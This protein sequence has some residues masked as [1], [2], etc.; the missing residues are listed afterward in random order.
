MRRALPLRVGRGLRLVPRARQGAACR[1]RRRG[2]RRPA[3]VLGHVLDGLLRLLHPVMPFVT[4]ELWTALTGGESRR[5]SRRG[6]RGE[7]RPTRD[8]PAAEAEIVALQAAGHRG[9]PVPLR[10]GAQ[11]RPAGGRAARPASRHAARRARGRRSGR[12]C[13]S[14]EPADGF[15]ATASLPVGGRHGRARHRRHHRRRRRAQAAGEGPRGG[16]K[17]ADQADGASSATRQFLAKAP[18][19]GGRR[20]SAPRRPGR[21]DIARLT[22]QLAMPL[23]RA[24]CHACQGEFDRD[25]PESFDFGLPCLGGCRPR[26]DL[27]VTTRNG[28]IGSPSGL[29][30]FL[31]QGE[32]LRPP[33][34]R[35]PKTWSCRRIGQRRDCRSKLEGLPW[36]QGWV[37]I[38]NGFGGTSG[39][40]CERRWVWH[41]NPVRAW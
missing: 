13:G 9:P 29:L 14:T 26:E 5:R 11:A 17:E 8:R 23:P 20:R 16:R 19:R 24:E 4:E 38:T 18:E 12:C 41:L 1:R 39:K 32:V 33:L 37:E 10:P 21:E 3:R 31:T 7:S 34:K 6:R 22:A 27:V 2:R 36:K 40:R 28:R 15:S 25:S 35:S 30:E